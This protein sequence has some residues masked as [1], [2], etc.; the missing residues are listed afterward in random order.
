MKQLLL[1]RHAKSSWKRS[2]LEGSDLEPSELDD[3]DRPLN[4]RGERDSFTMARFIAESD[5]MLDVLYSS[6]AVRA[7]SFAEKIAEFAHINLVPDLSFY[8][9]SGDEL[10]EIIC[11]LPA[12]VQRVGI[13]GH[14][15]AIT[16]AVNRLCNEQITNVPTAGVVSIE[17]S[18]NEWQEIVEAPCQLSYFESPKRLAGMNI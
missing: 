1:I 15:P 5:E 7:I 9:F 12:Q 8:T 4:A 17:C 18:I 16:Q 6:S 13:V 14:N 11:S 2:H 3:H 10:I